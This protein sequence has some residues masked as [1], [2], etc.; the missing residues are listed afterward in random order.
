[1]ETEASGLSNLAGALWEEFKTR[2]LGEEPI[3]EHHQII[4]E[5]VSLT[6]ITKDHFSFNLHIKKPQLP[7]S[8]L[9]NI[10][11]CD[12]LDSKTVLEIIDLENEHFKQTIQKV[13]QAL[14]QKKEEAEI[15]LR[16]LLPPKRKKRPSR[17]M[18][19]LESLSGA[20]QKK[21]LIHSNLEFSLVKQLLNQRFQ[22]N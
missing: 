16:E 9:S 20:S 17:G 5:L 2:N 19:L 12:C 22:G 1:M 21:T 11:S 15:T 4:S 18:R 13:R 8:L 10:Q 6:D 14:F 7:D 3:E